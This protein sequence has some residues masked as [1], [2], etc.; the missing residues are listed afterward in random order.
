MYSF[1]EEKRLNK[2]DELYELYDIIRQQNSNDIKIIIELI[3]KYKDIIK[4]DDGTLI[5][6]AISLKNVPILKLLFRCGI[7]PNKC[8]EINYLDCDIVDDGEISHWFSTD[9]DVELMLNEFGVNDTILISP[10]CYALIMKKTSLPIIKTIINHGGKDLFYLNPLTKIQILYESVPT[11]VNHDW[12]NNFLDEEKNDI[13]HP[14][15]NAFVYKCLKK[16]I[17]EN[18]K[19]L[20]P[21]DNWEQYWHRQWDWG[22]N[23]IGFEKGFLTVINKLIRGDINSLCLLNQIHEKN[24]KILQLLLKARI[25][26]DDDIYNIIQNID[27]KLEPSFC[28]KYVEGDR[29]NRWGW[30]PLKT[31]KKKMETNEKMCNYLK[32]HYDEIVNK[33]KSTVN[34]MSNNNNLPPEIANNILGYLIKTQ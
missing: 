8:F 5:S 25:F 9:Y 7:D 16:N 34:S 13:L 11:C 29:Y 30:V 24:Y 27:I 21:Y 19:I 10:L 3:D 1:K 26:N 6:H 2:M 28:M 22:N 18:I 15:R 23:V 4:N 31:S 32:E 14:V 20:K 12:L 33:Y 17:Y